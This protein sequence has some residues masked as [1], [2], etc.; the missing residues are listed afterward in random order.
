[1]IPTP[2]ND[3]DR[4]AASDGPNNHV[5]TRLGIS[6][7][8]LDAV[9][10]RNQIERLDVLP[11]ATLRPLGDGDE[12]PLLVTFTGEPARTSNRIRCAVLEGQFTALARRK[13]S[14]T[15][16][17]V[18][19]LY[20]NPATRELLLAERLAVFD[21]NPAPAKPK[22]SPRRRFKVDVWTGEDDRVVVQ[23]VYDKRA[24]RAVHEAASLRREEP[25]GRWRELAAADL[26]ED[27]RL[28]ERFRQAALEIRNRLA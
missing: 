23:I 28:I 9:C 8:D 20:T 18:V 3:G 7:R 1:V 27:E 25:A 26:D 24:S 11:P 21:A 13:V 15:S 5:L 12:L 17:E 4:T 2:P 22:R 16:I 10:R 19:D 6:R 14:V